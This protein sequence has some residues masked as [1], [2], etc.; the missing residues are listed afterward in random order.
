MNY[1]IIDTSK[2][3]LDM[4]DYLF[5][6]GKLKNGILGGVLVIEETSYKE[7]MKEW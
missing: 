5:C 6:Y 2:M 1:I 3:S 7:L 4:Q